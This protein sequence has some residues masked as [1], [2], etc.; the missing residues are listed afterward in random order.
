MVPMLLHLPPQGL[1]LVAF[2]FV[3]L[4]AA[5]A[6]MR[7]NNKHLLWARQESTEHCDVLRARQT[8]G[9]EVVDAYNNDC[10]RIAG[11]HLTKGMDCSIKLATS[12]DRWLD[13]SLLCDDLQKYGEIA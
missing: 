2:N 4:L 11:E 8:L 1:A 12:D 5:N 10:V 9:S 3:A 6:V 7:T 13:A